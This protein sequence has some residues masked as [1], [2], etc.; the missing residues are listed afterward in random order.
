MFT[1]FVMIAIGFLRLVIPVCLLF[2]IGAWI[3]KRNLAPH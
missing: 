3:E 1:A 2:A